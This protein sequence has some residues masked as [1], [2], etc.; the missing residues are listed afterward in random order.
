M[1]L[2]PFF[3]AVLALLYVF[4]S[5]QVIKQRIGKNISLGTAEDKDLVIATRIHGN[6]SEY[7]PFALL[8][9]WFVE[10]ITAWREMIIVLGCV[11]VVGRVLHVIGIN[12]MR[13]LFIFRQIGMLATFLVILICAGVIFWNYLPS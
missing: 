7:V 9:L 8:L 11:L 5:L 3:A 2:T 10:V 6:F 4:L 13:N 1:P 12:N